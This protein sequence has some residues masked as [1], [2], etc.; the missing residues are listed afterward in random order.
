MR[1]VWVAGGMLALRALM[2]GQDGSIS[3]SVF[4]AAGSPVARVELELANAS[5]VVRDT[6]SGP[7]GRFAIRELAEGT[8]MLRGRL[9]GFRPFERE[10]DYRG[11]DTRMG[12]LRMEVDS[13]LMVCGGNVEPLLLQS[14]G[15]VS[16]TVKDVS[17][18]DAA[19]A[20]VLLANGRG[21]F[22]KSTVN[23]TGHFQLSGVPAGE[24][25]LVVTLAG[26]KKLNKKIVVSATGLV[27]LALRLDVLP[28][29]DEDRI[30][31]HQ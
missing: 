25:D 4:D 3:G 27:G 11:G 8:Y 13:R 16:G 12:I 31:L 14:P 18:A 5:G 7:D 19:G 2:A 23:A 26:F 15:V 28:P 10:V 9:A 29:S 24:Y 6:L 30:H 1:A 22:W 17:D 21:K 20:S